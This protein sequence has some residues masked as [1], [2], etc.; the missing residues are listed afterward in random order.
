MGQVYPG[1]RTPVFAPVGRE[2]AGAGAARPRSSLYGH[3]VPKIWSLHWL[4]QEPPDFH[5]TSTK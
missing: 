2:A 4:L 1:G 3:V 5:R